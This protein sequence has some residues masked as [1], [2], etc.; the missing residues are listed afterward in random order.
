MSKR[1]D[2]SRIDFYRFADTFLG[3]L[4]DVKDVRNQ[5]IFRLLDYKNDGELS[6]MFMMQLVHNVSKD[7]MF[8]QEILK[9]VK[10]YK[11]KNLM[12]R[13]ASRKI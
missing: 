9:L 5:T 4:D 7:S 12:P 3:L 6:I 8:G 1:K 2:K 10:E 11:K 13:G